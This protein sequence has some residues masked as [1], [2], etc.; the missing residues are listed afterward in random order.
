VYELVCNELEQAVD[1]GSI[2]PACAPI[3]IVILHW[4]Q[5]VTNRCGASGIHLLPA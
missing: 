1:R 5:L 4:P 2:A 3:S